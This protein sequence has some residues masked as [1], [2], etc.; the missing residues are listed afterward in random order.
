MGTV[1]GRLFDLIRYFDFEPH[2][3]VTADDFIKSVSDSIDFD[4]E[5]NLLLFSYS[6][7]VIGNP[8]TAV[9]TVQDFRNELPVLHLLVEFFRKVISVTC[10]QLIYTLCELVFPVARLTAFPAITFLAKIGNRFPFFL[11]DR[12]F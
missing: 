9:G 2:V 11:A 1:L 6:Q 5:I 4:F 12:S 3:A 8:G 7:H 10:Y